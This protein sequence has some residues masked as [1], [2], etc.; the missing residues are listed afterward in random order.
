MKA[1]SRHR[2]LASLAAAFVFLA[3]AALRVAGAWWYRTSQNPDYGVVVEMVRHMADGSEW[4]AFFWG[5]SYMGTLEPTASVALAWLLGPTP[6]AVCLGT[7]FWGLLLL[8][9]VRRWAADAGGPWAGVLAMATAAMGPPGYFQYMVSPRGGYALGLLLIV[10]ILREGCRMAAL[11]GTTREPSAWRW[12]RLGLLAGLA[13]WNFWLVLPAVAAAGLLLL[14]AFRQRLFR[15]R[16]LLPALV[17]FALGSAPFW[18]YNVTHAWASFAP[19]SSGSAGIRGLPAVTRML[20]A[21]RIPKMLALGAGPALDR[22]IEGA[23]ALLV[24]TSLVMAWRAGRA[25]RRS[26]TNVAAIASPT[27]WMARAMA[28]FTALFAVAYLFSSFGRMNTPRYLLPF[29]PLLAVFTGVVT[30][31][32]AAGA[33]LARSRTLRALAFAFAALLAVAPLVCYA[34]S[35]RCHPRNAVRNDGWAEVTRGLAEELRARGVRVAI[36][37]YALWGGNWVANENPI[38][39]C[40]RLERHRPFAE[41]LEADEH[42]A[43]IENFR[44]FDHFL[45]ATGGSHT[46]LS[47]PGFR[48]SVDARPNPIVAVTLPPES[49]AAARVADVSVRPALVDQIESTVV[50]ITSEPGHDACVELDLA[51]TSPVCG[52]RLWPDQRF[53]FDIMAVEAPAPDG[54]WRR[55]TP[56]CVDSGFHWYGPT[57]FWG[58]PQH[59]VDF[60][61]APLKTDRL[62][63]HFVSRKRQLY[64]LLREIRLLG[65]APEPVPLPDPEAVARELIALGATRVHANRWLAARL[66]PLLPPNVWVTPLPRPDVP[67]D[68]ERSCLVVPDA[69]TVLVADADAAGPVRRGLALMGAEADERRIGGAVLFALRRDPSGR[70]AAYRGARFLGAT[71]HHASP[72]ALAVARGESPPPAPPLIASYEGDAFGVVAVRPSAPTVRAGGRLGVE[73]E[74]WFAEGAV[75]PAHVAEFL[76]F[77]QNG[78]I[79]FQQDLAFGVELSAVDDDGRMH[80]ITRFAMT[81]PEGVSG[82]VTPALGLFR[83]GLRNRRLVP[84]TNLPTH[85]RRILLPPIEIE[86]AAP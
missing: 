68:A 2:C 11:A 6:F 57:F 38:F 72:A 21:V 60:R 30:T 71:L 67:S 45:A 59:C 84:E 26:D 24:A 54:S 66:R 29:V 50:G 69:G 77:L 80:Y 78:R 81:V 15:R 74:W 8:L 49:I 40:P 53:T 20:L 12:G 47:V 64:T 52:V 7:A 4:P 44:G 55:L 62:R 65:P 42:P 82:P 14:G 86:P 36:A 85:R 58:G 33:R 75:P 63:L 56:P 10:V 35:L 27:R 34:I 22:V 46:R 41:A 83:P 16:T 48:V 31:R 18:V 37:D 43:V 3:A 13:F 79:V 17:G 25:R 39:C 51:T 76:H 19:T 61:F 9:A 73:V 70:L 28:L 1:R 32:L 23:L 5:Q